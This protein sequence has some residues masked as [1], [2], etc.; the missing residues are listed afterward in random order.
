VLFADLKGYMLHRLRREGER[1]R[2]EAE[3]AIALA[4]QQGLPQHWACAMILRGWA[5]TG[6]GHIEEGMAEM[7]QGLD[8]WCRGAQV[9]QPH[10]LALW[11]EAYR[12]EGRPMEGLIVLSE[13]LALV[14]K[15]AERY[16]EAE[17]YRLKGELLL[18]QG[19]GGGGV[20][21]FLMEPT[22]AEADPSAL[23]EAKGC[24]QKALDVARRQEAKSFELRAAM[25]L[26]RLWQRQ[27]K[28]TEAYG[29]LAP[30][31][32]WFTEGFDTVD[33]QEAKLLLE[34]LS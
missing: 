32:G 29:L 5:L 11:A 20:R 19:A 10:W 1:T 3:A 25:S 16:Y 4:H 34:G 14:E 28:S 7:R 9:A 30:V 8:T 21:A 23:V 2:T 13:A 17:L 33:L 31:Y 12:R 6:Q 27:G 22:A 24:F 15:H 26:A 18:M